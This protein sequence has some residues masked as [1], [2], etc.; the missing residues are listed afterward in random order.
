MVW[1]VRNKIPWDIKLTF[2]LIRLFK[3]K[4][5]ILFQNNLVLHEMTLKYFAK[6]LQN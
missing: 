5:P 2:T 3:I 6:R 1:M 4:A